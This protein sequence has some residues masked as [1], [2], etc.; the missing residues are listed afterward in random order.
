MLTCADTVH[1]LMRFP[2]GDKPIEGQIGME[3]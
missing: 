1:W 2:I 3:L